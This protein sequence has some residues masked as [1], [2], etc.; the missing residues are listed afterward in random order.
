MFSLLTEVVMKL[1]K[2]KKNKS[3]G[4]VLFLA[5]VIFL[6]VLRSNSS[7]AVTIYYDIDFSS[8]PHTVGLPPV[9]DPSINTPSS[10]VFGEPVVSES[11]GLLNDQPLVFNCLGN[12]PSFYYD[13]IRLNMDDGTGFYY[14]AFDVLTQNLIGSR[15]HFVLLYDTPNV[16]NITFKNNGKID[17]FGKKEVDYEDNQLFHLEILMDISQKQTSIFIN[18][19]EVYQG[20]F[21]PAAYLHSLRFSHGLVS[22]SDNIDTSTYVG[23]DNIFV[24]NYVPE[25]TTI[26]LLGLG[27]LSLLRKKRGA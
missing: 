1:N 27:A 16:Q 7:Y 21:S 2:E 10:I 12:S 23:L 25:P 13:Q 24:A 3:M 6:I 22:G 26:C 9:T 4:R 11:L 19:S 15:N 8:P 5:C 17:L 20:S 18:Y 14:T